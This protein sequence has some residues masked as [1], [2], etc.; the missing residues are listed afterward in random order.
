MCP[1]EKRSAT[2]NQS[3]LDAFAR[4][5]GTAIEHVNDPEWLGTHSPLAQA[6]VLGTHLNPDFYDHASRGQK[7]RDLLLLAYES[8]TDPEQR[9]VIEK[10]YLRRDPY[11]NL[12]GV[13]LK[14]EINERRFFRLRDRA[15][16]TIAQALYRNLLPPL[17]LEAPVSQAMIGREAERM[18]ALP[19]LRQGK[20]LFLTGRSGI[21]KSTFAANLAKEWSGG[22][23]WYTLRPGLNDH[24][25]NLVFA[26]AWWLRQQGAHNAW[27]QIAT[28]SR[29]LTSERVTALLRHDLSTLAPGSV[30]ICVDEIDRLTAERDDHLRMIHLLENL[31]PLAAMLYIGQ[32]VAM[33]CDEL[34]TL[35]P[36]TP[37]ELDAWRSQFASEIDL[38]MEELQDQSQGVP[39]LLASI[40]LLARSGTVHSDYV[41]AR[42]VVSVESFFLRIWRRLNRFER[43]VIG[44]LA[45]AQVAL[46]EE[47][48]LGADLVPERSQTRQVIHSMVERG[49]LVDTGNGS[50]D[51]AAI[52]APYVIENLDVE[53]RPRLHLHLAQGYEE[54]GRF[55]E[56][57]RHW[58]A[59]GR[60]EAGVWVW[61][62]HRA[63]EVNR[64]GA[65]R[66][67]A[68][69]AT[70]APSLLPH[71][72]DRTALRIALAE[73]YVHT[74]RADDARNI[75]AGEPDLLD[76]GVRAHWL[77]LRADSAEMDSN[78]EQ[79]L[80]LYRE[81]LTELLGSFAERE[82]M[83][84]RLLIRFHLTRVIDIGSAR[85]EAM[86]FRY[87]AE[88]AHGQVEEVAGNYAE[89]HARYASAQAIA[90]DLPNNRRQGADIR[91]FLG[92]L[93]LVQGELESAI[94][95]LD[96]AVRDLEE[97]GDLFN[98]LQGR[99]NLAY[100]LQKS[101]NYALAYSTAF[102]GLAR[103]RVVRH[104]HLIAGL[105][106][107]AAEAAHSLGNL[108]VA[109]ELLHEAVQQEE[110]WYEHW[111]LGVLAQV[112]STRA[113]HSEAIRLAQGAIA[114]AR[115]TENP[116][117]EAWALRVHGD[118]L[119]A[120]GN[121]AE[122]IEAYQNARAVYER[123]GLAHEVTELDG[124]LGN[125]LVD[126]A[127]DS[128]PPQSSG[129]SANQG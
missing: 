96:E 95:M 127:V 110:D 40:L 14:I 22:V 28:D 33:E 7:L 57:M 109:E 92:K 56:S 83:H 24:F 73:L 112:R 75:L 1:A 120:S 66:A 82:S 107:S 81:A 34:I 72:E 62:R 36:F 32:R 19:I 114:S 123:L 61:F 118:V 43:T 101:G 99:S 70:V 90:A 97:V 94:Q 116:Y 88:V 69:L 119:L 23:F 63:D 35:E 48:L 21:G 100:A 27:Q 126:S 46:P 58:I 59:G 65:T 87:R 71:E 60:P 2:A 52:L 45:V 64:G 13:A 78:L 89:A 25:D 104:S 67:M 11:L 105:A 122:A 111:A 54:R 6:W 124:L 84:R 108:D 38:S 31:R 86:Q 80:R 16:Q 4:Q 39:I 8:V 18:R 44:I 20:T 53:L 129:T 15:V 113:A 79:S 125:I 10:G 50:F 37:L 17:R 102:D 98:A 26:L 85:A 41:P 55:V 115:V 5:V 9:S 30:V 3:V 121:G 74:G 42:G 68:L 117:S 103:A 51:L 29:N 47:L 106:T 77:R 91:F 49:L 93:L 76:K 12:S 128:T